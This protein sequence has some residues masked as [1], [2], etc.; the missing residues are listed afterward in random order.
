MTGPRETPS[1]PTI[2]DNQ[3]TSPDGSKLGSNDCKKIRNSKI[4]DAT[5]PQ[6]AVPPSIFACY[7]KQDDSRN[8]S[9]ISN[10]IKEKGLAIRITPAAAAIG[11]IV[12]SPEKASHGKEIMPCD[13]KLQRKSRA[14][15]HK[16]VPR[17]E[18]NLA[19]DGCNGTID[20]SD[21]LRDTTGGY[22]SRLRL[23]VEQAIDCNTTALQAKIVMSKASPQLG[24]LGGKAD[25]KFF[26][27][28]ATE[29][30]EAGHIYLNPHYL[31][32][33]TPLQLE[34]HAEATRI[35]ISSCNNV[36]IAIIMSSGP[37]AFPRTSLVI[38]ANEDVAI[39]RYPQA[40]GDCSKIQIPA[41]CREDG[42]LVE[43]AIH[44]VIDTHNVASSNAALLTAT[45][46]MPTCHNSVITRS[47][48]DEGAATI[49]T[50]QREMKLSLQ[51]PRRNDGIGTC[52]HCIANSDCHLADCN[53]TIEQTGSATRITIRDDTIS[54]QQYAP[55]GDEDVQLQV[56]IQIGRKAKQAQPVSRSMATVPRWIDDVAAIPNNNRCRR[57]RKTCNRTLRARMTAN[58]STAIYS[59]TTRS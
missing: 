54:I 23:H 2:A 49:S 35:D 3:A 44:Y 28:K 21:A 14:S 58:Q 57:K 42:E 7:K 19:S 33:Q 34:L 56:T 52:S 30:E 53:D 32:G 9:K 17:D 41:T 15:L 20:L 6:A 26:E 55:S 59:I 29:D 18:S 11:T 45:S 27:S 37:K 50:R 46:N 51:P 25:D 43:A 31:T 24:I 1:Q 47:T 10:M 22:G 38:M 12:Q 16:T 48:R 8:N 40:A 4:A 39:L 36:T 13:N 5:D